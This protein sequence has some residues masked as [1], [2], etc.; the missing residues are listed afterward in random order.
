MLALINSI[1]SVVIISEV[2]RATVYGWAGVPCTKHLHPPLCVP[3][4]LH[5]P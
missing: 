5:L 3:W 1:L 4:E 2:L